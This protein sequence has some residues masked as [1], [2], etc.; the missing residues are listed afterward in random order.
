MGAGLYVAVAVSCEYKVKMTSGFSE[1]CEN[2]RRSRAARKLG[3]G[4]ARRP[5]GPPYFLRD[6]EG[7]RLAAW[8]DNIVSI[9]DLMV[10]AW[11]LADRERASVKGLESRYNTSFIMDGSTLQAVMLAAREGALADPY[12]LLLPKLQK[13]FNAMARGIAS[14][15]SK[16]GGPVIVGH[17]EGLYPFTPIGRFG[18]E[19]EDAPW[20]WKD[21]LGQLRRRC[22]E[23][24]GMFSELAG[25]EIS[26]QNLGFAPPFAFFAMAAAKMFSV[27]GIPYSF[28]DGFH[29]SVRA[30]E[31]GGST[32]FPFYSVREGDAADETIVL[33]RARSLGERGAIDE[34]T[35]KPELVASRALE[36]AERSGWR[37]ALLVLKAHDLGFRQGIGFDIETG[38]FTLAQIHEELLLGGAELVNVH[39]LARHAR[40]NH[41]PS[42]YFTVEGG[43][44]VFGRTDPDYHVTSGLGQDGML[45][46]L[47]YGERGE[48]SV[49]QILEYRS[50]AIRKMSEDIRRARTFLLDQDAR[51][52]GDLIEWLNR[53]ERAVLDLSN[54]S[55]RSPELGLEGSTYRWLR[56]AANDDLKD[57]YREMRDRFGDKRLVRA[58]V[59]WDVSQEPEPW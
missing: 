4:P 19:T 51:E 18:R 43:G 53:I 58:K 28:Q 59:L 33:T 55:L 15:R 20:N 10:H 52:H 13:I 41:R 23:T 31:G 45:G 25:T 7:P 12:Q 26:F 27:M 34:D 57:V 44:A 36:A 16:W 46:A 21:H 37:G 5:A 49:P 8:H 1:H 11:G 50:V 9:G 47:S 42:N 6:Y 54:L 35:G 39:Q 22:S 14:D 40:N 48:V 3:E 17:P 24:R 30:A 38:Q 2:V 29:L 56:R 32:C